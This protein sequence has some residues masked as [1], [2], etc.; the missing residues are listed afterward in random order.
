MTCLLLS[1]HT[2]SDY[3][4]AKSS[5]NEAF[6]L[7]SKILDA[8]LTLTRL[9]QAH[10]HPRLTV[11]AANAQLDAQVAEMQTLDDE[12]QNINTSVDSVKER[13]KNGARELERL[14]V[15]RTELEKKVRAQRDQTED[16]RVVGLYDW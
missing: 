2:L 9:R 3:K 6:S 8:R 14:R 7:A 15:E 10:P 13:V 5:T 16:S 11:D 12:L 1:P 4:K